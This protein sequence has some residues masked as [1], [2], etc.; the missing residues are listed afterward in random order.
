MLKLASTR[1]LRTY[2]V[3]LIVLVALTFAANIFMD[4]FGYYG[5]VELSGLNNAKAGMGEHV[6]LG[7]AGAIGTIKPRAL[8][9]GNSRAEFGINPEH[10][11]WT[12]K[13][14]YNLGISGANIYEIFRYFQHAHHLQPVDQVL[15][16]LDYNQF[17]AY[18]ENAPDFSEDRLEISFD[19]IANRHYLYEDFFSTT[20]SIN[21]VSQSINTIARSALRK[22]TTYLKNG[23]RNWHNDILFR[24]VIEKFDSYENLFS[25]EESG[26]FAR[27]SQSKSP[28]YVESFLNRRTG[29]NVFE[30]FRRMVQIA[31]RDKVDMRFAI[32]PSHARYFECH[33]LMGSWP[34]WEEWKRALVEII[35]EEAMIAGVNPFP[36]W[37]FSGFN[38]L[39]TEPVPSPNTK[40]IRMRWYF[41]SSHYTTDLGDLI[42]DRVFAYKDS[43]RS[44]PDN[45]GA[46]ITMK[47][48]DDHLLAI[49]AQNREFRRKFPEV[50]SALQVMASKYK[51]SENFAQGVDGRNMTAIWK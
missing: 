20:L 38:D 40:H 14:V 35:E 1:F 49:R 19:E 45:F 39:T 43:A 26:L 28:P 23:Q 33:R 21:A 37:D 10:P 11:G 32:G 29:L 27:R 36:I 6:R 7:K 50:A 30:T 9:L 44:F 22:P 42:Q 18:W 31:I 5:I 12:A 16:L 46:L 15:F 47:N 51:L 34:M 4:P 8:V 24:T 17:N 41:E 25:I 13:P 48:I 3:T 2:L